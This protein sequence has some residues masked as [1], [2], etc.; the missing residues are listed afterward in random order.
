MK[1]YISDIIPSAK[2]YLNQKRQGLQSTKVDHAT[3]FQTDQDDIIRNIAK[4]KNSVPLH[5][6]L[7]DTIS[8]DIHIDIFPKSD[9]INIK[10][11]EVGYSIIEAEPKSTPVRLR[12]NIGIDSNFKLK[13]G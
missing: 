9:N 2:C 1:R 4:L 12:Y 6:S 13:V 5:K 10:T 11:N 3:I 7:N 8:K